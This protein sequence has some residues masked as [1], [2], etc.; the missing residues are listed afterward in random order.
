M[1]HPLRTRTTWRHALLACS[2]AFITVAHAQ[3]GMRQIQLNAVPVTLVYP[4]EAT[5]TPLAFGAFALNVALNAPPQPRR[6]R[7]VVMSH[8]TGG[9]AVPDHA[10]AAALARAGFVV[11]QPL[12]EGDNYLDSRSAG[13]V[14][15]QRRPLE[16]I[17]VIDALGRHPE[18]SARL[19]LDR[20]GV[21]GM[22]AGGVTGISLAGGQWRLLDLTRHCNQHLQDD[23]AFC[24]QGAIE[25]EKRAERQTRFDRAAFWPAFLLPAELK[26]VHGGRT[27]TP[28]Q[29][30]V[31]PDAR[32]AAVTLAVPV[33]AMFSP[34]SLARIR[35]PV[36]VV[37]AD[38]D[39]VLVPRFH[40]AHLLR[41]CSTCTRLA[42]LTGAGHFD[43]LWPWPDSVARE[44][45]KLQLRG[46]LPVPGFD[47]RLR[48]AAHARIEDF[49]RQHLQPLP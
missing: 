27:P 43:V 40:S 28:E 22:S 49:H 46:G 15:M 7:L 29:P 12:H 16:V 6:H 30:D 19:Q 34:Q 5:A 9:S 23:E 4:T 20:V 18:W 41:H 2:A 25:P 33:A 26:A 47:A 17:R 48:E 38:R 21:H 11:A 36:G 8:G 39:E 35:I 1:T 32:V 31:R 13:P 10:L 42:D 37:S 24:F 14:A 3:V 44:V 45:A